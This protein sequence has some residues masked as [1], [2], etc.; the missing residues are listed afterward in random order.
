MA[1]DELIA[2]LGAGAPPEGK[3]KRVRFTSKGSLATDAAKLE[4]LCAAATGGASISTSAV[5]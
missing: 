1:V 4:Q 5:Y 2:T 3:S